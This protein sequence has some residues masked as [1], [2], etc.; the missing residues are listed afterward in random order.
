[1]INETGFFVLG[2]IKFNKGHSCS[3]NFARYLLA[4]PT[5]L[6][7]RCRDKITL[8]K[9]TSLTAV[10][11][12]VKRTIATDWPSDGLFYIKNLSLDAEASLRCIIY[13][14][15]KHLRRHKKLKHS[16]LSFWIEDAKIENWHN[17]YY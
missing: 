1:M 10:M 13:I 17:N 16:A 2:Q 12:P 7:L 14:V 9:G 6:I 8:A 3:L 5:F 15:V 4:Y 11:V